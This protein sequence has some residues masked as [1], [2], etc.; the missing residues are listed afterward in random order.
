MVQ[1]VGGIERLRRVE[2]VWR[3]SKWESLEPDRKELARVERAERAR[4]GREEVEVREI[5]RLEK[6]RMN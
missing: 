3:D 5:I 4:G 1:E 2:A 6:G